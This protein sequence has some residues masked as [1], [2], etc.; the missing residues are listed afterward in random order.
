MDTPD[1]PSNSEKGKKGPPDKKIVLLLVKLFGRGNPL[2]N[3]LR[4]YLLLVLQK[5][6]HSMW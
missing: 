4:M 1:F 3:N 5:V 6:L 2:E